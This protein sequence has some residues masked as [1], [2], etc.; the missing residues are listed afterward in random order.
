MP[1]S[2]I[3]LTAKKPARSLVGGK[4]VLIFVVF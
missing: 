3:G 2:E 1:D 4:S